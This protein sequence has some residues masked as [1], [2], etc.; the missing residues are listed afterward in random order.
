MPEDLIDL[1]NELLAAS[2]QLLEERNAA[3]AAN[4]RAKVAVAEAEFDRI[5]VVLA[6]V[7][8]AI[9]NQQAL[10]MNAVAARLQECVET[11]R[12]I[13][14]SA[15][16]DALAKVV[17]RIRG[18]VPGLVPARIL[19]DRQPRQVVSSPNHRFQPV[20]VPSP[21]NTKQ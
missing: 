5:G 19:P 13:G 18:T 1:R 16:A 15:A 14:L 3:A 4:D 20:F 7:Q 10:N 12:A 2:D 21:A 17:S 8:F 6:T 11:E 9:A